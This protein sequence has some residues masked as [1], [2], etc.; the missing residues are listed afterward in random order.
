MISL[1]MDPFLTI[2]LQVN[3]L[4][5]RSIQKV[6]EDNITRKMASMSFASHVSQQLGADLDFEPKQSTHSR[7]YDTEVST[8]VQ[9]LNEHV[10]RTWN[11][12]KQRR[13]RVMWDGE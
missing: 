8:I 13:A 5:R 6:S 11:Q 10:G 12:I 1:T 4:A 9:F 3:L 7:N 2:L